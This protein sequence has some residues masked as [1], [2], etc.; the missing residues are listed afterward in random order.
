[1][2]MMQSLAA[3]SPRI[4]PSC[5]L[6]EPGTNDLRNGERLDACHF[7]EPDLLAARE[8]H[9]IDRAVIIGDLLQR[10]DLQDIRLARGAAD[11]GLDG[12]VDLLRRMR[13]DPLDRPP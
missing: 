12:V 1:M 8:A 13:L 7:A 9:G 4:C 3:R 2:S 10:S 11:V 5:R 6:D